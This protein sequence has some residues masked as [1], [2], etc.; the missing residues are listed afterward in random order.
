MAKCSYSLACQHPA[1]NATKF[2][3][4]H[5]A[6]KLNRGA[7]YR[8]RRKASK[9]K[10]QCA[11]PHC[12]RP[13]WGPRTLC[14]KHVIA[15]RESASRRRQRLKTH[16]AGLPTPRVYR[17][18]P[19]KSQMPVSYQAKLKAMDKVWKKYMVAGAWRV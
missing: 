16:A 10:G 15:S 9:P 13:V 14:K 5:T 1:W 11:K 17:G 8:R 12:L 18:R 2:C 4:V 19:A 3:L 7:L 6:D